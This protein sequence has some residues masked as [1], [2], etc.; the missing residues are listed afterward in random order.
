MKVPAMSALDK[1]HVKKFGDYFSVPSFVIRY[2][3]D[4][5]V[6]RADGIY[7]HQVVIILRFCRQLTREGTGYLRQHPEL[8]AHKVTFTEDWHQWIKTHGRGRKNRTWWL[9]WC[10]HGYLQYDAILRDLRHSKS[11]RKSRDPE[12]NI[13]AILRLDHPMEVLFAF[14]EKMK[15][16]RKGDEKSASGRVR[17][18]KYRD[19]LLI[20]LLSVNPLR[21]RHIVK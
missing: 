18:V 2:I 16:R 5:V 17:A 10:E 4:F 12:Y 20:K 1:V 6:E 21:V 19:L 7:H 13:Q 11:I 8:F 15:K 9:A 14:I 3:N